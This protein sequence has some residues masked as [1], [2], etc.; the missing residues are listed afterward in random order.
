MPSWMSLNQSTGVLTVA[1]DNNNQI[2][3]Y[4]MTVTMT[5]PDSGN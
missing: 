3:P 2:G 1:P 4:K 5:T